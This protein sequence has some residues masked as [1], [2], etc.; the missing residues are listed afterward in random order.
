MP[1]I[2]RLVGIWLPM[3]DAFEAGLWL[4][5]ITPSEVVVVPRPVLHLRGDQLHREDGPAVHWPDGERY[6]FLN[7]VR[8]TREIVETPATVLDPR[9]IL[10]EENAEVR[11]EIVRKVG[12]ERVCAG[13]GARTVSREG[14]YELLLLDL[15]DGRRRPFLKMLNPSI[16]VY[17]VEGVHP[18]CKTVRQAL[19]WRNGLDSYRE[20]QILT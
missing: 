16:G 8:V 7:G 15:Q 17:H 12:I 4:Y 13:L 18:D 11:R 5:W 20:P 1:E 6:Y 19:A 3:L 9:L 2:D 14:D 10:H